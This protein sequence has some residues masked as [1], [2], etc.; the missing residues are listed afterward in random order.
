MKHVRAR[1][2]R[3]AGAAA[4]TVVEAEEEAVVVATGVAAAVGV[5]AVG[6]DANAGA[7]VGVGAGISA[8]SSLRQIN[9][10]GFRIPSGIPGLFLFCRAGRAFRDWLP[11]ATTFFGQTNA[12]LAGDD[13]TDA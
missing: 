6:A 9:F 10:P 11:M 12:V 13:A 8:K 3:V 4:D 7:A 2:A 5:G 1:N